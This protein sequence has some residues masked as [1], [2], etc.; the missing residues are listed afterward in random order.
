MHGSGVR[1]LVLWLDCRSPPRDAGRS[2]VNINFHNM[3]SHMTIGPGL[4]ELTQRQESSRAQVAAMR[5]R[6]HAM[7]HS[8]DPD[9]AMLASAI[10]H[11]ADCVNQNTDVLTAIHTAL[12]QGR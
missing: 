5:E 7:A 12:S 9:N 1:R 6:I 11:L 2:P 8:S 10:L 3:G 4:L